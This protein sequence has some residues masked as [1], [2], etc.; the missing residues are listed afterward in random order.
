[1]NNTFLTKGLK[2]LTDTDNDKYLPITLK[3]SQYILG[4]EYLT[5]AIKYE[6]SN[7]RKSIIRQKCNYYFDKIDEIDKNVN[8]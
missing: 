5:V 7:Q 2:N 6:N 8:K 3:R 1:M 4:L